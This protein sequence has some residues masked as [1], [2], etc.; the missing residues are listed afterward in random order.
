[1]RETGFEPAPRCRDQDLNL[2]CLPFHHSRGNA[3]LGHWHRCWSRLDNIL[4]VLRASGE[5]GWRAVACVRGRP[6]DQGDM[7]SWADKLNG[8]QRAVHSFTT[9]I[10][11][12]IA[13]AM[14]FSLKATTD[15]GARIDCGPAAYA[16]FADPAD[17][18]LD[19]GDCRREARERL[20]TVTG[21]VMLTA[22]G[23]YI[24]GRLARTPAP[25]RQRD[26]QT[27]V[28]EAPRRPHT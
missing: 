3:D 2:A 9:A 21:L 12:M 14:F 28:V 23:S 10:G 17:H 8:R 16:L 25:S 19:Q 26:T 11:L 20:T 13:S 18:E 1:V 5:R 22:V 4:P 27:T 15:V 7:Y 24:G 6:A